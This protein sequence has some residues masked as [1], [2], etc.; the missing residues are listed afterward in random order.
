MSTPTTDAE[1]AALVWLEE[2]IR[3][4]H[5]GER[6]ANVIR[7]LLARSMPEE[8]TDAAIAAMDRAFFGDL[9]SRPSLWRGVY[10]ALREELGGPATRTVEVWRVEWWR[11]GSE[12]PGCDVFVC[13]HTADTFADG[14]RSDARSACVR[15]TGPHQ[16]EMPA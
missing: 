11:R 16:H 14:V 5:G 15:V 9:G 8:P 6:H 7:A 4:A 1:K 2:R 12:L 13:K 3:L 10:R